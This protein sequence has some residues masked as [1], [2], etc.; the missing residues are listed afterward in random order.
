MTG[1][2][3]E[4]PWHS[5]A[6]HGP[7]SWPSVLWVLLRERRPSLQEPGA[8]LSA[9]ASCLNCA[10][11]TLLHTCTLL[12]NTSFLS[13]PVRTRRRLLC[14]HSAGKCPTMG[15]L[16]RHVVVGPAPPPS[17]YTAF[18][19]AL[20]RNEHSDMSREVSSNEARFTALRAVHTAF[21]LILAAT[22]DMGLH[23]NYSRDE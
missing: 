14:R 1:E 6:F 10:P 11:P 16:P 19:C 20:C 3:G 4:A 8:V 2:G 12:P 23:C 7:A 22:S 9:S 17:S 15:H 5:E 21:G 18:F 13:F